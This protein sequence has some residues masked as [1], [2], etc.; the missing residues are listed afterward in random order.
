MA[1]GASAGGV[2]SWAVEPANLSEDEGFEVSLRDE[3]GP[4]D[5]KQE[6]QEDLERLGSDFVLSFRRAEGGWRFTAGTRSRLVCGAQKTVSDAFGSKAGRQMFWAAC[7]EGSD[8]K[9]YV[10]VG[11]VPGMLSE[12]F[13][14]AKVRWGGLGWAGQGWAGLGWGSTNLGVVTDY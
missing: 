1:D 4:R 3:P 9:H 7:L 2:F 12:H 13:F 5:T 10:L 6:K 11:T 8:G 14:V